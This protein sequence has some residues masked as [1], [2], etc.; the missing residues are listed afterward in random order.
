MKKWDKKKFFI[1]IDPFLAV[2]VEVLIS[3]S[4]EAIVIVLFTSTV[5]VSS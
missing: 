3:D 1:I 2:L 5:P 4:S